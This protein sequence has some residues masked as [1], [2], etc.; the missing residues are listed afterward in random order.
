MCSVTD[1]ARDSV[2]G[3]RLAALIGHGR[4][5][6][7]DVAAD[8]LDPSA[9]VDLAGL[10]VDAAAAALKDLLTTIDRARAA[11][12]VLTGVVNRAVSSRQLIEG[13]YA[14]T[15]RFL[16]VEARLSEGAARA[17]VGRAHALRDAAD[18]GDPR[19]RDSWLAGEV[20]DDMVALLGIG[21]RDAVKHLPLAERAAATRQAL[22]LVLPV[23][24]TGTVSDVKHAIARLRFVLD[25]DGTSQAALDAY[26]EQSLNWV[27]AGHH[28]RLTAFLDP[29]AAAAVMTVLE[30]QVD[31][32]Q[33]DGDLAVED[34]V[35]AGLDA[36]SAEGRRLARAR[37]AHLRALAL[38]EVM[39]GLLGRA[40]V[41]M[42]H[43][44]RPHTVL[45]VDARDLLAGLGGELILPA[46]DEPILIP[47]ETVR[48]V[49][50]D[51]GLTYVL[52]QQIGCGRS[53]RDDGGGAGDPFSGSL[54][55]L[56][57]ER[58]KEVLYVG[59]EHRTAPPRLR[60]AL[61]ARDRHCQAPGCRRSPRRCNA[62]HVAHWEHGGDTTIANC[63]LLCERHHRAVHADQLTI[64][65]DE[66]RRPTEP[67]YW[68]V[69]PPD[70][71]PAP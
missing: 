66:R 3:A 64:S 26:T 22:D 54:P 4:E 62:H 47:T 70:R 30:Q 2:R 28:M 9:D 15:R 52:T 13:T 19:V 31:A 14:S 71:Q 10:P 16:E 45:T 5:L 43:G 27:R 61:E 35:P 1:Q 17:L 32:W 21:V 29:E 60:R 55:D 67:G 24:R 50:F 53:S 57:R 65:R 56:L 63:V 6:A 37:T 36:D 38:G 69:H 39:T 18:A 33:R 12:A 7:D 68:R 42:H 59:R 23:A 20:S 34:R 8:L 41:G 58:A 44:V 11:A 25:P 46:Q 49:L 51:Y 48:R 40:E